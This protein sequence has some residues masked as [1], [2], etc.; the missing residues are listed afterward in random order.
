MIIVCPPPPPPSESRPSPPSEADS[1]SKWTLTN[2]VN[3]QQ[4]EEGLQDKITLLRAV[5]KT[6]STIDLCKW[7][8][9]WGEPE[10]APPGLSS[11]S[12]VYIYRIVW[13]L[14]AC[15]YLKNSK[16]YAP[17]SQVR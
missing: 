9:Y 11:G 16:K 7:F 15:A 14:S 2:V 5:E 10:R 3:N 1:P 17:K 6:D 4:R 13:F 8:I 12:S